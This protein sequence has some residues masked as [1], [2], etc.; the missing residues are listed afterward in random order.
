ML[1]LA[2]LIAAG[3]VL[4]LAAIPPRPALIDASAWTE[5]AARTVPG[6]YHIHTTRSD[7]LGDR[8]AVAAAASRAGLKFVI[9]TDH[10]DGTR[11]PDPPSY[12]NGVLVLDGVEISTDEGHY[13]AFDMPRA[14]YPLGGAAEAVVEDVAR[15]GGFGIA[16]HPDSLKP[17]LRWMDDRSPVDGIEW[18]NTDSEWRSK[19]RGRLARAGLAYLLRPAAAMASLFDR[20]VTL[21][22]WDRLTATR[23]VVAL[24][25]ADAHGGVKRVAEDPGRRLAGLVGIPSYDASFRAFTNRVV[26]ERPLSGDA[27]ADA[28][29]IY[30][31]IRKGSVFSAIDALAGP[32]FVDFYVEAGYDRIGMGGMLPA[33]S[34]ATIVARAPLPPDA[35]LVLLN[36]GREVA[37]GRGEIR[38]A[39]TGAHGAYRVEVRIPGAP[40]E[41]AIPWLVS[42]PIYFGGDRGGSRAA[43]APEPA[44]TPGPATIPPFPWRIEKDPSSSAILRTSGNEVSLEYKLGAGERNN[45]FVAVATDLQKQAFSAIDLSLVGDRPLRVSVQVRRA[46]GRRWGRSSYVDQAGSVLHIPLSTLKPI[47]GD[48]SAAIS[49]VDVTSIL[50]VLDLANAPPGRAGV[51]RVR[52][53]A[54]IN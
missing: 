33:D 3:V 21:D 8:S 53:S 7:G 9:L 35:Q 17:Q 23:Q 48:A 40:G 50:L 1:T 24:A 10:G 14:P 44:R 54:L 45:Q 52:S 19:S 27:A 20:P 18:L 38:R 34:D 2:A 30:G 47:G 36:G 31:A 22:R 49:A 42:N 41:P 39:L 26:L 32:A 11:P 16:A 6:A 46:D 4:F 15:L 13:V 43:P 29:A 28:R 5:L 12:M 37:G 51:L 25:G